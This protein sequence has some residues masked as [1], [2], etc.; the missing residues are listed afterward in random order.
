VIKS[1]DRPGYF[2][3]NQNTVV[4]VK[5]KKTKVNELLPG[6]LPGLAES[7]GLPSQPSSYIKF[8][9]YFFLTWSGFS[10]LVLKLY[11]Q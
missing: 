6:F 2:F 3:L 1:P 5:N 10:P 9:F 8:F 7:I 4:L 11:F